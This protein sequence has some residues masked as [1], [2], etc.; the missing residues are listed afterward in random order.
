MLLQT[1]ISFLS[2]SLSGETRWDT[3]QNSHA[4]LFIQQLEVIE[5]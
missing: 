3:M 5:P 4:A 2:L 1:S